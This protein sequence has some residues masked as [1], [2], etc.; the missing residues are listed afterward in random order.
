MQTAS[1]WKSTARPMVRALF[2]RGSQV[3][4]MR[5]RL[6]LS[7]R[8]FNNLHLQ[9]ST[10]CLH[11]GQPRDTK[12]HPRGRQAKSS[13][14]D[15]ALPGAMAPALGLPRGMGTEQAE[16]RARLPSTTSRTFC[17]GTTPRAL[18]DSAWVGR[19]SQASWKRGVLSRA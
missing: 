12:S 7:A 10:C 14:R 1:R 6:P 3:W 2:Q 18:P 11:R 13:G 9:Y 4:R 17:P 15:L 16:G 8:H 19:A 5:H